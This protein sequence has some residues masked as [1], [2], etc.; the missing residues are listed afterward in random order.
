LGLTSIRPWDL[1]PKCGQ[2]FGILKE[3]ERSRLKTCSCPLKSK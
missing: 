1:I 2:K 3:S